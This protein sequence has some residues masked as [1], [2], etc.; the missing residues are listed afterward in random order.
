MNDSRFTLIWSDNE[1]GLDRANKKHYVQ[2][3][4]ITAASCT[5]NTS[6]VCFSKKITRRH[7]YTGGSKLCK[8]TRKKSNVLNKIYSFSYDIPITLYNNRTL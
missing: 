6:F 1:H 3:T 2:Y 5:Q 7:I 4:N 8:Y